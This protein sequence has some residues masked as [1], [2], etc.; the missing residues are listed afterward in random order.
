MQILVLCRKL[1]TLMLLGL[2]CLFEKQFVFQN[3][4]F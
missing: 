3:K 4:R 1:A 2:L